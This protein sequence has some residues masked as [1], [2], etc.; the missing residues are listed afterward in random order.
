MADTSKERLIRWK[1]RTAQRALVGSA[2]NVQYYS[3]ER[4]ARLARL[5]VS[6]TKGRDKRVTEKRLAAVLAARRRRKGQSPGGA[7]GDRLAEGTAG[8]K[9]IAR[10]A[11]FSRRPPVGG[12]ETFL[13][14]RGLNESKNKPKTGAN[15]TRAGTQKGQDDE[16]WRLPQALRH[17]ARAR[18][19]LR[20]RLSADEEG[21]DTGKSRAL[22]GAASGCI[23][24]C[25][26]S[27]WFAVFAAHGIQRDNPLLAEFPD[28]DA[29][30]QLP[31]RYRF[32]EGAFT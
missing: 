27:V 14:G 11:V 2:D 3:D 7:L 22:I 24:L 17:G 1:R 26:R 20:R 6:L 12:S 5:G 10:G 9:K 8:V 16:D 15:P 13:A 21:L 30:F 19:G 29:V 28:V 4:S 18:G 25:T 31:I 23:W 32:A